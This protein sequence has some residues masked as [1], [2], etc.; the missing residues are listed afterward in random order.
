VKALS[1]GARGSKKR[2]LV[3][4]NTKLKKINQVLMNRVERSMD[5]QGSDF[6]LFEH[7]ILLE[8]RVRARTEALERALADLRKSHQELEHAKAEAEHANA[9]KTHFLAAASHDLLQPLNAVRLFVA[10]L[11]ET[12]GDERNRFLIDN[13]DTAFASI[14]EL[15]TDLLD[16]SKLDAGAQRVDITEFPLTLLLENLKAEFQPIATRK[17]LGFDCQLTDV[18]LRTD[19]QLLGRVL[20]NLISNAI[21][22]TDQGRIAI[23][24]ETIDDRCKITV[25]DTG[26]G[27]P[28]EGR[29]EIFEEF[30]QLDYSNGHRERGHGLGLA[31]V[32]RIM[33]L[34]GDP[35]ELTSSIDQGSRF[36]IMAPLGTTSKIEP[37]DILTLEEGNAATSGAG[38]VIV[39]ENEEIMRAGMMAL[40]ENWGYQVVTAPI[41][42]DAIAKLQERSLLPDLIIAD[43]HLDHGRFGTEAIQQIQSTYGTSIPAMI[44]TANR[45]REVHEMITDR[46]LP[47]LTKPIKPARLRAL[48]NH[49]IVA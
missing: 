44:I 42:D 49:L 17:A 10:A 16:I 1:I 47:L 31:I 36:S 39:I 43:Y 2:E 48:M 22:Y 25:I 19:R 32:K 27:I 3:K 35:I 28:E 14:E 8:G 30:K 40:L 38:T 13:I 6:T 33:D 7:A 45:S 18:N 15:L 11:A 9:S 29:N 24:I 20:R 46:K 21:R 23:E 41:A 37:I 26:R 34:L 4:E 12:N 5:I